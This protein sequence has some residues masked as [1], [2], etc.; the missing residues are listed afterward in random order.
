[1]LT[2]I[3]AFFT[4]RQDCSKLCYLIENEK[5]RVSSSGSAVFSKVH[6]DRDSLFFGSGVP[7][8]VWSGL[9]F[10]VWIAVLKAWHVSSESLSASSPP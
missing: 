8:I 9:T 5:K 10:E 6:R 3:A 2:P 1:M 4:G 7:T